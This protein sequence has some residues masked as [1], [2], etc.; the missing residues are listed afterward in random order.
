MT[1]SGSRRCCG[2]THKWTIEI[3]VRGSLVDTNPGLLVV[4]VAAA[5][6]AARQI[7]LARQQAEGARQAAREASRPYVLVTLDPSPANNRLVDHGDGLVCQLDLGELVAVRSPEPARVSRTILTAKAGRCPMLRNASSTTATSTGTGAP[8]CP[9]TTRSPS[10]T[11]TPPATNTPKRQRWTSTHSGAPCSPTVQT[12]HDIAKSLAELQMTVESAAV[13]GATGTLHVDA[14]VE[15][16]S[17]NSRESKQVRATMRGWHLN[18]ELDSDPRSPCWAT[19]CSF[20]GSTDSPTRRCAGQVTSQ[21]PPTRR[22]TD[23]LPLSTAMSQVTGLQY[24]R[25]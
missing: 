2:R 15:P 3:E 4:A 6:H 8:T 21:Q 25:R 18:F 12:A 17:G 5:F 9:Q 14:A 13:L 20:A 16:R 10:N 7:S 22:Q 1:G 11:S 24:W 19:S 23:T